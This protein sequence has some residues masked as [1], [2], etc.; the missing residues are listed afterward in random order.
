MT[1]SACYIEQ[2]NLAMIGPQQFD[3]V[4]TGL[5]YSL[6][7]EYGVVLFRGCM[8][9]PE[10]FSNFVASHSSRLSLDPARTM[11]AGAAQLVDAGVDAVGLHCENGNSPFWPDITWFY[12]ADAPRKGSQTTVCDGEV[13][14]AQL[15][16]S[17]R[18]FFEENDIR[19]SRT[20]PGPKWRRLVCHYTPGLDDPALVLIDDLLRNVA[21]GA[22]TTISYDPKTDEIGYSFVVSAI[23]R[24]SFS[25]RG[26][27][28]NSILGPS[29]NYE[30]PLIDTASGAPIPEKFLAE[31]ETVTARATRPVGWQD[32]DMVMIDNRRVMHG[33]EAICDTRRRIYNALSYR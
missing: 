30:K 27:F 19:Y 4:T 8:R 25:D 18:S 9:G 11:V 21:E 14:L 28:A 13:V 12:C 5:L 15:S 26:A 16:E 7:G 20:V 22:G 6:L 29:F 31:I 17:C 33:R 2:P 1:N 32:H 23:Q 3:S 24:S 10:A